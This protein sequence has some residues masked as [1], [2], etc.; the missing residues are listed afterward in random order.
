MKGIRISIPRLELAILEESTLLGV[1]LKNLL[2]AE[3]VIV[4]SD[5]KVAIA[6]C[7]RGSKFG[8]GTLKTFVANRVA[9]ILNH[10]NIDDIWYINTSENPSDIATRPLS[11]REFTEKRDLWLYGP[12]WL[13][14]DREGFPSQASKSCSEEVSERELELRRIV[15]LPER[16]LV[17]TLTQTQSNTEDQRHETQT[18]LN[19]Y[20][21]LLKIQRVTIY[22]F[23]FIK[24]IKLNWTPLDGFDSRGEGTGHPKGCKGKKV[25]EMF[26][27]SLT[28]P[29]RGDPKILRDLK[30]IPVC[31]LEE[32][33]NALIFWIKH[34]QRESFKT[35]IEALLSED[36]LNKNSKIRVLQPFMD[37][38]GILKA[39]GRIELMNIDQN[40]KHPIIL[41]CR[42][43][44]TTG[45]VYALVHRVW[46]CY[47]FSPCP[48]RKVLDSK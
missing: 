31:T 44:F 10:I 11:A 24:H 21:N 30:K 8:A 12:I 25:R 1:K 48:S 32:Y 41:P 17:T 38:K 9:N 26:L 22:C 15:H 37:D 36:D 46:R 16:A 34:A 42:H 19:K 43:R 20:S 45:Y 33:D 6:Q 5:S 47:L 35:E 14:G 7:I 3:K 39:K 40:W 27:T 29:K 2:D 4:L 18:L 23:R 13:R 28:L